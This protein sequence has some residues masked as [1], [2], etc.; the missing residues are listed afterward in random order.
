MIA[1]D[2]AW[3]RSW[4]DGGAVRS[5]SDIALGAILVAAG[6]V[7]I[8]SANGTA[9]SHWERLDGWFLPAV[10]AG[11][12][13][14]VGVVLLIRGRF[15]RSVQPASWSLV[16]LLIIVFAI[17]AAAL[18]TWRWPFEW[19]LQFGPSEFATLIVFELVVAIALARMSRVRAVGMA[20]LGLLLATIGTDLSTGTPRLTMGLDE[21]ADGI[22]LPIVAL[23]LIVVADGVCCLVSPTFF[24]ATYARLV[25]GWAA[26]RIPTMAGLGMRFAAALA[27]AA[28]CYFAYRLN[29]SVWDIGELL[30][31]GAFG[32]A[33][34]VLGWN[35][36]VLI[37]ALAYSPVLEENIRRAMLI[38]RG[39]PAVFV[40]WPI[41]GTLLLLACGILAMVALPSA[42]RSLLRG[43]SPS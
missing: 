27:I 30:V 35:R 41:S 22:A 8:A 25:A 20:L 7:A 42:R 21:L 40:R 14:L 2:Q 11:L 16:E 29:N 31:F 36:L 32:V 13:L 1:E 6:T 12:L 4:L 17:G 43:R 5:A 19:T 15:A 24:L 38:S 37:L 26:P 3:A 28:V 39:D 34:K 10:V 23:G 9:F 33:C 18:G